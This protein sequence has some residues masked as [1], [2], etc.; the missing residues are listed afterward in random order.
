MK[1]LFEKYKDYITVDLTMYVVM[2][3]TIIVS[4]IL[5]SLIR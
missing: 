3:V 4:V 2:I 1:R 5:I